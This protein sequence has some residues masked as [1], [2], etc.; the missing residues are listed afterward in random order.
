MKR[1]AAPLPCALVATA[2]ATAAHGGAVITQEEFNQDFEGKVTRKT[3]TI[4]V[5]GA[6]QKTSDSQSRSDTII[7]Y[8]K[9]VVLLVDHQAKTYSET[10][11]KGSMFAMGAQMASQIKYK[12]K[13]SKRT[14]AGYSCDEYSVELMGEMLQCFSRS[15]P[16]AAEM[17]AAA[18]KMYAALGMPA[19]A[20]VPEGVMLLQEMTMQ[21]PDMSAMMPRMDQAT[22]DAIAR[23]DPKMAKEMAD[24]Q[25]NQQARQKAMKPSV[26]RLSVTAIKAESLPASTFQVPVGYSKLATGAATK[27]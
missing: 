13:G 18:K 10:P 3:Q 22:L 8:D 21:A 17:S 16:G 23:S 24:M 1:F 20:N 7:D 5:E 6:R 14:V 27:P 19:S 12:A 26:Q 9:G 2:F 4:S 11:L 15:A 25:K